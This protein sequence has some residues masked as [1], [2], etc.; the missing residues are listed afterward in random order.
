MVF[1]YEFGDNEPQWPSAS[2]GNYDLDYPTPTEFWQNNCGAS[3]K[4]CAGRPYYGGYNQCGQSSEF[5]RTFESTRIHPNTNRVD[6]NGVIWTIDS[7]DGEQFTVTMTDAAGNVMAQQ[8][9]QGNNF[10]NLADE[11]ISCPGSVGGWHDGYF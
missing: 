1:E 11:T 5:W 7:W 9:W 4:E 10:A 3:L 6:F 2:P 8:S